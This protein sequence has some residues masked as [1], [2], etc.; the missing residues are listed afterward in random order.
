[1]ETDE[2]LEGKQPSVLVGR[3]QYL[4]LY[5]S[6]E[7][8]VDLPDLAQC[9]F[10]PLPFDCT[11]TSVCQQ[12]PTDPSAQFLGYIE[13][14]QIVVLEACDSN[15]LA[16]QQLVVWKSLPDEGG[17]PEFYDKDWLYFFLVNRPQRAII[18]WRDRCWLIEKTQQSIPVIVRLLRW[19]RLGLY[20]KLHLCFGSDTGED[21]YTLEALRY[22]LGRTNLNMKNCSDNSS[23]SIACGIRT[24]E[25]YLTNL[26]TFRFNPQP[27]VLHFMAVQDGGVQSTSCEMLE[28][29]R[30]FHQH[31]GAPVSVV[32]RLLECENES[33]STLAN[34]I[35]KLISNE[36]NA[37]PDQ[38]T[39]RTYLA[40]E[41]LAEWLEAHVAGDII[42][43]ADAWADRAY[44]LFGDAVAS[45]LPASQLFQEVHRSNMSKSAVGQTGK[46]IKGKSYQPPNIGPLLTY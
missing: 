16:Q 31:V 38:L 23:L 3:S 41:E 32:P 21:N 30:D 37:S 4:R 33:A 43:A 18:K 28:C 19:E 25:I 8:V 27:G 39:L 2:P 5:E 24:R 9:R 11:D 42:A 6:I 10:V 1:M 22:A 29:V 17:P 13:D 26:E 44:V 40:L 12:I 7:C 45:G 34:Q 14:E 36:V 15:F 46:G 20:R 35:R